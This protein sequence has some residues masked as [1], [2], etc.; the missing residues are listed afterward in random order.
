MWPSGNKIIPMAFWIAFLA[1][2]FVTSFIGPSKTHTVN[3]AFIGETDGRNGGAA[4]S[5]QN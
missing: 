2:G 1:L 4:R 5:A 3:E